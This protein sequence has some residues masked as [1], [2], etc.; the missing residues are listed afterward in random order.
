[1]DKYCNLAE[2]LEN[3]MIMILKTM[4]HEDKRKC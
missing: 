2:L 1:M 3:M 4:V